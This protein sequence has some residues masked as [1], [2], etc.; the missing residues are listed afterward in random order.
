MFR[1]PHFHQMNFTWDDA[2]RT[3]KARANGDLLAGMEQMNKIW[4][5]HCDSQTA[6][7]NGETDE[8]IYGDDDDFF[9]HWAYECNAYNVVFAGFNKLFHGET[10]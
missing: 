9:D 7:Y 2:V 8:M 3:I 10:A 1:I 5:Q 6:Y 4:K